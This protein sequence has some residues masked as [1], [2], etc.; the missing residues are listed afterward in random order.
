MNASNAIAPPWQIIN[1]EIGTCLSRRSPTSPPDIWKTSAR[2]A[3]TGM[4]DAAVKSP[5]PTSGPVKRRKRCAET[6][7]SDRLASPC[8][9]DIAQNARV[10]SASPQ[11]K[12]RAGPALA[13]LLKAVGGL[14]GGSGG[15][16]ETTRY[17]AS[18]VN[19]AITAMKN[20]VGRH[21]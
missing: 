12:S 1:A 4:I 10:L 21:P 2:A 6:A 19:M 16:L 9:S 7:D 11:V 3:M 20:L 18:P 15:R 17:S 5:R 8:A 14:S 13:D